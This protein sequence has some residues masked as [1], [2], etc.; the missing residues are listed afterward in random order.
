M[1]II[2]ALFFVAVGIWITYTYPHL[3]NQ[4]YEY[5]GIAV[6]WALAILNDLKGV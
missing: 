1:K 2:P 3:A 6:N 4:A 5:I